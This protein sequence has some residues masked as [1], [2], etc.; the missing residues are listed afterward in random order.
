M[1]YWLIRPIAW[2]LIHI[3]YA[4]FGGIRFEG[5]H[6]VPRE[7]GV[8]ITPNH[9][10]DSDPPTLAIALPRPCW[11]MAKE[12]IFQMKIIGPLA[13]W[14]HG[15]PVKRYTADRAALRR[16]EELL[17]EGEAVVIFPEGKLSED[18]KLQP[19]LPGALLVARSADVP[20]VPVVLIGTDRILPYGKQWPR[21]AGRRT[22]VRFGPPVTVA[23]L[24]GGAKGSDALRLGAERLGAILKALQEGR[25][26]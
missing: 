5:R 20:I 10:S 13:R 15:F 14:L 4:L 3:L 1:P 25:N 26:P 21:P 2:V 24:T 11:V 22:I 9:I 7:G 17:E 18:G 23:Q 19:L 16:A 8:L 12:E 6:Y